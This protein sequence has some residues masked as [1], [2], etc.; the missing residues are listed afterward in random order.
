MANDYFNILSEHFNVEYEI[1]SKARAK[2]YDPEPFVEIKPAPDLA[3]RVEGIINMPGIAERIRSKQIKSRQELAFAIAKDICIDKE[4]DDDPE[5]RLTTAVRVGLAI[6]TEG[7]LVAP[8]E[9]FQGIFLHKNIDDSDYI[10]IVFAGPIRGAGGTSTALSVALADYCRRLLNIGEYKPTSEEIDRYIEEIVIYN[11]RIARLQYFPSEENIRT[12]LQNCPVCIDGL[13]IG[14]IEISVHRDIK[15]RDRNGKQEIITNR[16][17]GGVPLVICEGIAQ[18][19]KSV[20]KYTKNVNLDWFW[21]NNI[22]TVD[23][24]EPN[25]QDNH[26]SVFL[27]ELVA[28]RPVLAYPNYPGSFRLRYGRS[29]FTGI[30]AKGFNPA[31]MEIL[32]EFIAIGTQLKIEKPGK[33]CIA[34]PVD[35][36]EGPFVKL[37]DGRAFRIN[38][39]EQAREY[40]HHI[41]KILSV[42]DILVTVGDFRKTNTVLQPTSYVEEYWYMQLQSAG[43][44]GPMPEIHSFTDA[45]FYSKKYSIPM[46]PLY[47]YDYSDISVE[48]LRTLASA[49]FEALLSLQETPI[50]ELKSIDFGSYSQ[51]I[52]PILEKLC[53][54]HIENVTVSI[55]GSDLQSLVASIGFLKDEK[56]YA[57]KDIIE[58]IVGDDA[59]SAINVVSPFKIMRRATRIGGRIGR[60]EKAYERLMKPAPNVLFPIEEYGGKERSITKAYTYDK[61][62]LGKPTMLIEIAKYKCSKG[63]EELFSNYC[64]KHN[65]PAYIEGVCSRCGRISS[66]NICPYCGGE[67]VFHKPTYIDLANLLDAAMA[68]VH[69]EM[70]RQKIIKGVKGMINKK[71]NIEPLEKGILRSLY[72]VY[73]FKD[74]TIRF[75][76]TDAPL[77]HFY[78]KEM[79]V[80]IE[81]L[82]SM[83]YT[84]DY[85][86]SP[87]ENPDQLVELKHQDVILN[88]K[89]AN[90]LLKAAQFMDALLTK[91]YNLEPFYNAK[92]IDDLIGKYVVTLS[93]HTSAGVLGRIIGFTD[94]NVGF[95]HPYMISARRRNCDGDEDTTMLLLDALIN[96][97]KSYLPSSIGGTMDAP[98]ILTLNINPEEVDDEVWEMETVQAY[99]KDFYDK[100]FEYPSPS[101]IS[102]DRVGMR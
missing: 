90:Y 36:I 14:E 19:A 65:S 91:F 63:G 85:L 69:T 47:I 89:G 81:K 72:N 64:Y 9:G 83:G 51:V 101:L 70:P 37:D 28:G 29:R 10:S 95:A 27:Q 34:M 100:T 59:L 76:A 2:G 44:S 20:L 22:I 26:V 33:G 61:R 53:I 66:E 92:T 71:K 88:I 54:P 6:L 87:L 102:F 97:S 30:A 42:G 93:P 58:K 67:V 68:H 78:P 38:S 52:V 79:Q 4:F 75:D 86:G 23:K 77:T 82:K 24:A 80:S 15:R 5:K 21:L 3:A 12:I 35:S 13:P 16:I 18:K 8:T 98:L 43:Y 56:V 94:A 32:D 99:D 40:K 46:H 49:L 11:S 7:I 60:P 1:A 45:Y 57:S 25:K 50:N 31:T 48:E 96:F 17:R 62:R 55:N 73:I 39:A 74:G 41:R 84:T